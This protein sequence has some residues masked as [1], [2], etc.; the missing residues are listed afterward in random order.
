[1]I[2]VDMHLNLA[3]HYTGFTVFGHADSMRKS[4]E[5]DLVCSAVSGITLTCALGLKDVLGIDGKYDS[6]SGMMIVDIGSR[7]DQD[8]DLLIKT[9]VYG[10]KMIQE[11]YPGSLEV[12]QIKG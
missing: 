10:L 7:A 6:D 5:Y 1:M 2:T 3:G 12:K 4:G 9:M 8:S 11:K